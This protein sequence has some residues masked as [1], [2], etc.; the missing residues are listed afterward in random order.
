MMANGSSLRRE[1]RKVDEVDG[2]AEAEFGTGCDSSHRGEDPRIRSRLH[3]V[4]EGI[5]VSLRAPTK[6]KYV[7]PWR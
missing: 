7:L 5:E 1:V 6:G 3:Y 2:V 4:P